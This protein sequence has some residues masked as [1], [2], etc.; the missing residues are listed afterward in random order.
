[1][2]AVS[3][4]TPSDVSK[5]SNFM[6]TLNTNQS[7]VTLDE[8]QWKQLANRVHILSGQ[9]QEQFNSGKLMKRKNSAN[10]DEHD[11]KYNPPQVTKFS[12]N[13]EI[14]PTRGLI[15]AHM[16]VKFNGTTH[17][18]VASLRD[19]IRKSKFGFANP[20]IRINYFKDTA[21][22]F[23]AYTQKDNPVE[24]QQK[25]LDLQHKQIVDEFPMP[26]IRY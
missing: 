22:I 9:I 5:M 6:I 13:I 19:F 2:A 16:I 10:L 11:K 17:I 1:M 14:G 20:H 4:P 3:R 8:N 25:G 18:D 24:L 12:S 26:S 23:E 21:Q 15:H 7:V